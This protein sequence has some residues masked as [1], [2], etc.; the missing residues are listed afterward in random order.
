MAK[1]PSLDPDTGVVGAQGFA[2]RNHGAL[3]V[4]RPFMGRLI[5][6]PCTGLLYSLLHSGWRSCAAF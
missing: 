5:F 6:G 2:Y 4:A 1:I 3:D